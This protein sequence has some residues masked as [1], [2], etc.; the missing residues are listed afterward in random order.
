MVSLMRL[1]LDMA[2]AKAMKHRS[3]VHGI[4]HEIE[5]EGFGAIGAA[6][7]DERVHVFHVMEWTSGTCIAQEK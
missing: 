2:F 5:R 1:Q 3:V 6:L 7:I 4:D